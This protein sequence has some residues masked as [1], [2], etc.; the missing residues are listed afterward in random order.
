M[1]A[2]AADVEAAAVNRAYVPLRDAAP[3]VSR[4]LAERLERAMAA[5]PVD[6]YN[7]AMALLEALGQPGL[8]GRTWKRQAPHAGRAP[9]GQRT[10]RVPRV[11]IRHLRGREIDLTD[12]STAVLRLLPIRPSVFLRLCG[13]EFVDDRLWRQCSVLLDAG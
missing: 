12:Q 1:A 9:V 2:T 11:R 5:D 10:A 13:E 6:R 8:T 7:S 3:H 4:R